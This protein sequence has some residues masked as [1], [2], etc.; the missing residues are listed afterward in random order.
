MPQIAQQRGQMTAEFIAVFTIFALAVVIVANFIPRGVG[1]RARSVTEV[2][3]AGGLLQHPSGDLN[4]NFDPDYGWFDADCY[5]TKKCGKECL[6]T[7]AT[8]ATC[9]ACVSAC[10]IDDCS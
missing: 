10:A 6:S 4:C 5:E 3:S 8:S 2:I 9:E 1:A 7:F